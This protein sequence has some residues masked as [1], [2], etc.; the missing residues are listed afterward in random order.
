LCLTVQV[1]GDVAKRIEYDDTNAAEV[2]AADAA[3]PE[4]ASYARTSL[5]TKPVKKLLEILK[6][7]EVVVETAAPPINTRT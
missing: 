1:V 2:F 7:N 3:A 4:G 6:R 5:C